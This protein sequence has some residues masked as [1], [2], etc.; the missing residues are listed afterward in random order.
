MTSV[1]KMLVTAQPRDVYKYLYIRIDPELS[2]LWFSSNSWWQTERQ[3]GS[4]GAT[5]H[6]KSLAGG[7]ASGQKG[8]KVRRGYPTTSVLPVL[9]GRGE[10]EVWGCVWMIGGNSLKTC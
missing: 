8:S 10:E 4:P 6:Q 7:L 2:R 1:S 9:P 5:G 3:A